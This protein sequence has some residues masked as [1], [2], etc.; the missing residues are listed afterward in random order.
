[1]L[2]CTGTLKLFGQVGA[3]VSNLQV[4][5]KRLD[6]HIRPMKLLLCAMRAD[7]LI[8]IEARP[9]LSTSGWAPALRAK[10]RI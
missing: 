1:M 8:D 9:L 2:A 6:R 5:T 4:H 3:E 10:S 7:S